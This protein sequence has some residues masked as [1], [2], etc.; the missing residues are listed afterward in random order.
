MT[1]NGLLGH[2]EGPQKVC[3]DSTI[4]NKIYFGFW[5]RIAQFLIK[6]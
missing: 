3:A 2:S 1:Q 6:F 4:I 5:W